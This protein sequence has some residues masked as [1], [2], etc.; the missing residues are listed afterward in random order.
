MKYT[1]AVVAGSLVLVTD[2]IALLGAAYNRSGTPVAAI[3]LTE[4]E[5]TL[6]RP[7]RESTAL[8]LRLDWIPTRGS[9]PS[10]ETTDWFNEAKLKEI[11]YDLRVPANDPSA[12]AYYRA[13]RS[14]QVFAVFEY[15]QDL[16]PDNVLTSGLVAVDVGLRFD[17]LRARYP[18]GRRYLIVPALV[19]AFHDNGPKK[20]LR[21]VVVQLVIRDISVPPHVRDVL[22]PFAPPA[23]DLN[24]PLM[25]DDGIR[26]PRYAVTLKYGRNFEPW[27]ESARALAK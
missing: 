17:A 1:I 20:S 27:V 26:S 7:F 5:L 10:G 14:R 16:P 8:F 18:D 3:E 6:Q 9:H 15:K 23:P 21:G 11:G 12:P 2:A 4:R 22:A 25:V 24:R 13:I 19:R